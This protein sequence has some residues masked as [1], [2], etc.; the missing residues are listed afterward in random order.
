MSSRPKL[1]VSGKL[2]EQREPAK[3]NYDQKNN[4]QDVKRWLLSFARRAAPPNQTRRPSTS[5]TRHSGISA[6]VVK[7]WVN[8][9]YF[10]TSIKPQSPAPNHLWR[11]SFRLARAVSLLP[12]GQC[13]PIPDTDASAQVSRVL[14]DVQSPSLPR[15]QDDSE[16]ACCGERNTP[17]RAGLR[18][19][20]TPRVLPKGRYRMCTRAM[21][22]HCQSTGSPNS[23]AC[24]AWQTFAQSRPVARRTLR[25][26][27]PRPLR[28]RTVD[29]AA[30]NCWLDR[31]RG[32]HSGSQLDQRSLAAW[33]V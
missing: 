28:S 26:F 17:S 27:R 4:R 25:R 1:T 5:G 16:L 30:G 3:A 29:E 32:K 15:V 24:A 31:M 9:G 11:R 7:K 2:A 19:W 20:Q 18:L 13:R 6:S 8:G 12:R 21:S 23:R 10:S 33:F 14:L 22:R